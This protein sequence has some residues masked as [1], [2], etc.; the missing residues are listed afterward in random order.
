L[1][2]GTLFKFLIGVLL[3][4]SFYGG[5]LGN[6]IS[7]RELLGVKVGSLILFASNAI[8]FGYLCFGMSLVSKYIWLG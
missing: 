4:F 6:M 2:I 5:F 8:W 3:L 7:Y 1:G